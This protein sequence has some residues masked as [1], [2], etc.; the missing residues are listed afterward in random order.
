MGTMKRIMGIAVLTSPA[1][2][3]GCGL[4][5]PVMPDGR[6]AIIVT[7]ADTSG[8]LPGSIPGERFYVDSAEVRIESRTHIFAA[9]EMTGPDGVVTFDHLD[10]GVYSVFATRKIKVASA[11]K[12]FTGTCKT[13]VRGDVTAIGTVD[14]KPVS[15]SQ[16]MINEIFYMGSC[17]SM[18][19]MYDVFVELA[20]TSDDTLYLDGM[21]VM[22]AYNGKDPEL[23]T[24]DYVKGSYAYQ[25]PGTPVTGREV[26]IY[27]KQIIVIASD[28]TNHSQ[29][30]A[31][32]IDLRNA[33]WEMFNAV[34][35]DFDNPAVPN[36]NNIILSKSADF[37]LGMGHNGVFLT[38][39]D[40]YTIDTEDKVR[41]PIKNVID[42][43]EYN[44]NPI[45]SKEITMRVDAGFAGVGLLKYSA[46]SVERR[47]FGLDTNDSTFDF[48]NLSRPTPGYF[49]TQ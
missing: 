10:A 20:N 23:E 21:L 13:E 5:M 26:P 43:V 40:E 7:V 34:S 48:R 28:A 1:V 8:F 42:G 49:H 16:L 41:V 4:D 12:I 11:K 47:E 14:V 2:F 32:S 19:Y 29:F 22:R 9:S 46:M 15:S 36:L 31:N 25:F 6:A 39:G 18:F 30:C 37:L 24:V 3:S 44:A 35:H 45:Y 17:A 33:D 27:P 38:T